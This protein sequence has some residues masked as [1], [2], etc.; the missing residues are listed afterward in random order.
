[1]SLPRDLLE[2]AGHLFRREPRRPRQASL[3][4]AI[5]AAYYYAAF[6]LMVDEGA[7]LLA[8]G[9][10]VPGLRGMFSRSFA[11]DE[12]KSVCQE[13]AKGRWPP[14]TQPHSAMISVPQELRGIART[15]VE[16]QQS[17]HAADYDVQ[18]RYLRSEVTE[19]LDAANELFADWQT[20]RSDPAAKVFLASLFTYRKIKG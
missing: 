13:V 7:R 8:S 5:S 20:V 2:Q 15:F 19:I 6:H 3:R 16:L 12:M 17:R 18:K 14:K 9:A 10:G 11:H 1:M 4:R